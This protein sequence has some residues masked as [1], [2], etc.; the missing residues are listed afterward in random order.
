VAILKEVYPEVH[1][2]PQQPRDLSY[3]DEIAGG[4]DGIHVLAPSLAAYDALLGAGPVDVVGT[5]LHGGIRGLRHARRVLVV[6]ID[7]RAT[8]IGRETGLAVIAR[9]DVPK[10]LRT[11]LLSEWPTRLHLPKAEVAA[12]LGQFRAVPY[13]TRAITT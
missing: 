7:N 13:G 5:R 11:R 10:S 2:W 4:L 1:F 12:F 9:A 8:E 6:A 3:L